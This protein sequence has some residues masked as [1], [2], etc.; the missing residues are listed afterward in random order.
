MIKFYSYLFFDESK[1]YKSLFENNKK[2]LSCHFY[3]MKCNL[4]ITMWDKEL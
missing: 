3:R 1:V 4:K 2:L